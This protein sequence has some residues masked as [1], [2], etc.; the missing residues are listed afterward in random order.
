MSKKGTVFNVQRFTLHDGPGIRTEFFLKGCPLRCKWCGNPESFKSYIQPGVFKNKCISE[1]KCGDCKI[2][3]PS[4]NILIFKEGKLSSID[5]SKCIKCMKCMDVCPS[6]A[7]KQWGKTMNVEDCMKEII[8]DKGFYEK[9]NGGVTVSGGDPILQID[10]VLQ[11]FKSCKDEDIHTCFESTFYGQWNEIEKILPYTDLFISDLKHM[12]SSIHK[13]YTGV[14]NDLILENLKKLSKK[15]VDII[16]RIPVI[17]GI[18][19]NMDNIKITA[20]Y[21]LN[22]MNNK[23]KVLQLLSFMHLGEEK[24]QSLGMDYS[25]KNLDFNREIFQNKI[26][27]IQQYFISRGINCIVGTKEQN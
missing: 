10:F 9:S 5:S 24:Y 12:D 8:K 27:E 1:E 11:L 23:I 15:N 17:P 6:D 14:E 4:E 25:M 26:I 7:I 21:I 13:K 2:V 16:L 19:D 20:D 18:N 22:D 3:C